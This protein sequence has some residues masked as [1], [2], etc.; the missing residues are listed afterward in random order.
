MPRVLIDI[1]RLILRRAA[2]YLPTGID[3]VGLAHVAHHATT[4]RAV[5][6]HRSRS[7]VL[8]GADSRAAF[9]ELLSGQADTGV[10]AWARLAGWITRADG[11]APTTGEFL[12]NTGHRGLEHADYALGLRLG[13]ALPIFMIHDLIPVTH[14]EYCRSGEEQRHRRR[15]NHALAQGRGLIVNSQATLE[16]LQIYAR[17]QML[18]MPPAVVAPL[19]PGLAPASTA[20]RPLQAPYFIVLGTIEPRKNH[21]LLLNLWR[22]LVRRLGAA[23]PHLVVIGR[24]GWECQE[25]L[26]LLDRCAALRGHVHERAGCGDAELAVWMQHAQA[27]LFPSFCEGYG[28]PAVEAVASGV[29]VIASDLPVFRESV[30]EVPEYASPVDGDRWL[31][32]IVDYTQAHSQSRRAQQRRRANFT[33]PSWG[34]HHRRVGALLGQLGASGAAG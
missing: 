3:R 29:P 33:V 18:A 27:L 30:A 28:M 23:A 14:P 20:T 22:I 19:A 8:Q 13:G 31:D 6:V 5:L 1:T 32:L 12:L 16:Q 9:A 21:L 15:I 10:A 26:N 7:C 25:T 17:S 4:A 11:R 34:E 24:R 2:G